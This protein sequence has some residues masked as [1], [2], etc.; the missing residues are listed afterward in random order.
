MALMKLARGKSVN[1]RDVD[2]IKSGKTA[3]GVSDV[4]HHT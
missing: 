1:K 3:R 2:R 4:A